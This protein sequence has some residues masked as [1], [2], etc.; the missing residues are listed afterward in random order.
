MIVDVEWLV[1]WCTGWHPL[2][3]LWSVTLTSSH[4]EIKKNKIL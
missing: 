1:E 2:W 4:L 3:S